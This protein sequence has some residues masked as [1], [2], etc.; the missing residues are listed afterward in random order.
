MGSI[1]EMIIE[2]EGIDSPNLSDQDR[3]YYNALK[4]ANRQRPGQWIAISS[5]TGMPISDEE[6]AQE[7][8]EHLERFTTPD[9]KSIL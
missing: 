7:W 2:E 3:A 6:A 8:R 5:K 9:G 4:E 1:I